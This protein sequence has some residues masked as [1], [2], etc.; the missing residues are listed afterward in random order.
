[1]PAPTGEADWIPNWILPHVLTARVHGASLNSHATLVL[2]GIALKQLLG[3]L[4]KSPLKAQLEAAA[5]KFVSAAIDDCGSSGLGPHPPR[6]V[7]FLRAARQL[8]ELARSSDNESL[9]NDLTAAADQLLAR[10]REAIGG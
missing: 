5:A 7:G 8:G 1:M 4:E 6:Y 9:R 3:S 10:A 2:I